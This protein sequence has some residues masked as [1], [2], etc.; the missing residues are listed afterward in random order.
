MAAQ[1]ISVFLCLSRCV[2]G[3]GG[4]GSQQYSWRFFPVF[5][6]LSFN[7]SQSHTGKHRR[8]DTGK[9][10]ALVQTLWMHAF[11]YLLYVC[12]SHCIVLDRR[13]SVCCNSTGDGTKVRLTFSRAAQGMCQQTSVR[14]ISPITN[15]FVLWIK[16]DYNLNSLC[17]CLGSSCHHCICESE[18]NVQAVLRHSHTVA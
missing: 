2:V 8:Q 12:S 10:N 1:L 15:L 6:G 3:A 14:S 17:I 5:F 13:S 4:F 11:I 16:C 7:V 9:T 18:G